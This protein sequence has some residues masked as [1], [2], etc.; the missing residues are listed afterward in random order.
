MSRS[1]PLLRIAASLLLFAALAACH[2][3]TGAE[4]PTSRTETTAADARAFPADDAG[5]ALNAASGGLR[6]CLGEGG[7][8]T[9]DAAVRFEPSGRVSK[10]DVTPAGDPAATCVRSKLSEVAVLPF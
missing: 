4:A 1:R 2:S 6:S 5:S 10:V 3:G 9:R 7:S 8:S